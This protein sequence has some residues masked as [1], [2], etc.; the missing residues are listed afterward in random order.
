MAVLVDVSRSMLAG[1]LQPSRLE[2]AKLACLD[3]LEQ[4]EGDRVALVAFAGK[5][6]VKCP[7][8]SDYAFF[9]AAV[10]ELN[11]TSAQPGGSMIGEA[12][13][14]ALN[15]VLAGSPGFASDVVLLTDGEDHGSNPLE[16]AKALGQKDIRLI[17]VGLGDDAE[18][19]L[20][21][22]I[23][24]QGRQIYLSHEGQP[25][26]SRQDSESLEKMAAATRAGRFINAGVGSFDLG[27]IYRSAA[28]AD[29]KRDI[30]G[31]TSTT[32]TELFPFFLALASLLL[33]VE[34][35][36]SESRSARGDLTVGV[37]R[38]LFI[39]A[40]LFCGQSCSGELRSHQEVAEANRLFAEAQY[41][42]AL[43]LYEDAA[44]KGADPA[45]IA[46][47]QGTVYFVMEDLPKARQAFEQATILG[48]DTVIA[49]RA[50]YNCGGILY[51]EAQQH[52]PS[53]PREALACYELSIR[54]YRQ[55]LKLDAKLTMAAKNIEIVR[56]RMAQID[57]GEEERV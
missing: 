14:C 40:A 12:L 7:L 54:H 42:Q 28:A 21:P 44:K 45:I 10:P 17:A 33:I 32:Y 34:V 48:G 20:I 50:H 31:K 52:L 29:E 53:R 56:Q 16:A 9:K 15:E 37:I 13:R 19:A 2:R 5:P 41:A 6:V 57:N 39:L 27:T 3:L 51:Q 26:W 22:L 4:L 43:E 35:I 47:N 25:V 46:F 49:A 18:G 23:D 30:A 11:P 8:T 36:L 55:A 38:R 1:D 24:Q